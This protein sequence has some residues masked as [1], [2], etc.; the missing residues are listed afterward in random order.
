MQPA[1]RQLAA[2]ARGACG[3][4]LAALCIA[5]AAMTE[6]A[7]PAPQTDGG[8]PLMRALKK[9]HTERAFASTPLATQ[10]V[11]N[12][13]WAAN[14]INRPADG[15]RTAPSA[16][17]QQEIALYVL[18]ADG[19]FVYDAARHALTRVHRDDVRALASTQPHAGEAPLT[20]VYVADERRMSDDAHWRAFY[21]A[22]DSGFVAQNVYLF[23]A[24][25]HLATVV[26]AAIDRERLA[27]ALR[28][29]PAQR[30]VMAQSVGHPRR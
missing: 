13:L 19:V 29:H 4:A 21:A 17:N 1:H 24:S 16:H 6:G 30:I 5:A 22:A 26:F 23:C 14:G 12:L 20:L 9:R 25:E 8:M 27:A 7:L 11:A 3:A 15:G 28:L 2:L 10:T 18:S